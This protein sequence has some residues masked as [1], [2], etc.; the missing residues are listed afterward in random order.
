MAIGEVGR[1][2]SAE[3]NRL[4][5]GGTYPAPSAY[6]GD[7]AAANAWAGSTAKDMLGA[8]NYKASTSRTPDNYKS[9]NAICNELAGTSNKEAMEALRNIST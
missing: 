3:L 9:L 6:K 1:G 2:F 7:L 4:A 5:N 8:L